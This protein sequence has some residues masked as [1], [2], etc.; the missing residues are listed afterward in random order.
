MLIHGV[1]APHEVRPPLSSVIF[2]SRN[3]NVPSFFA[4]LLTWMIIGWRV[5]VAKNS[6]SRVKCKRTGLCVALAKK[7]QIGSN[8]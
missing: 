7:T 5:G 4:P 6:S 1:V 2:T 3:V 8:G